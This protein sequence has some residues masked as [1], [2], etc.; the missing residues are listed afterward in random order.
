MLRF[1]FPRLTAQPA[2][3][4]ELFGSVTREARE[5]HWYVD[6]G[7]PDSLDGRFAVLATVAALVLVRL[8]SGREAGDAASVAL[9]ERFVSVME[10]EHREL[11]L[12]DPGLGRK[13]RKLV[14][15]LGR[16]VELWRTAVGK[17]D[18][19]DAAIA[20]LGSDDADNLSHNIR[21]LRDLWSRLQPIEVAEL[22]EGRIR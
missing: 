4:T 9:T 12:G 10:A 20:S 21:A 14:S 18:F 2:R 15:A 7:V 22:G 19:T 8:E 11:G 13:V 16:R 5:R 1:L 17:D 3:G 6:G